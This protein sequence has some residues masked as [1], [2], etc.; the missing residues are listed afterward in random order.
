MELKKY[1]KGNPWDTKK[2][3]P[4]RDRKDDTELQKFLNSRTWRKVS[5]RTQ[6]EA[7]FLCEVCK[8]FGNVVPCDVTDHLIARSQGGADFD[9]RNLMPMCAT[10]H[11]R[12]SALESKGQPLDA[13]NTYFGKIPAKREQVFE[14]LG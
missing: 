11:N 1:G 14:L 10:H 2:P 8:H 5:K 9:R 12:K 7:H 4:F 13:Y 6:S 3:A